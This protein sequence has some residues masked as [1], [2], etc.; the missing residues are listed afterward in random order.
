MSLAFLY[1]MGYMANNLSIAVLKWRFTS[2]S[3]M[4]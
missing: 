2:E 3:I 4:R 1:A